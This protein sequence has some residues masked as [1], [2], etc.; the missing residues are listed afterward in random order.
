MVSYIWLDLEKKLETLETV[1]LY[2]K[3]IAMVA[4][5]ETFILKP[6]LSYVTWKYT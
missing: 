4:N 6:A 1:G 2:H 5:E 3:L